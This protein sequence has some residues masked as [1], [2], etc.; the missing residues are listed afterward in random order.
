MTAGSAPAPLMPG[1][2][3]FHFEAPG[4]TACL[5]VHGF[6]G[7]AYELRELGLYLAERG[8]SARGVLLRGHGSRAEDMGRYSYRDWI[9]DVESA[10]DDLL[11][12][13]K[14]VFLAGLSMGGTLALNVAA[15]R[16]HEP[17][18]AGVIALSTPLRLADWRLSLLPFAGWL[19]RWH[20][21]GRPDIKD[22]SKWERHV[23]Y[24]RFHIRAVVQLM[25]LLRE[26]RQ[27]ATRVHQPLLVIQSR[28]DNTVPIFNAELILST[29][30]SEARRLLWLDNCYHVV[31]LD[32]DS[33][34]VRQ[35]VAAFIQEHSSACGPGTL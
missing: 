7:S 26:T 3:P 8:I 21:W 22:E 2:E 15:R 24:R 33:E 30:C 12:D 29:V 4:Q 34:R 35:E 31:T 5:L 13:G 9:A 32:Y 6:T 1:A 20:S 28:Q 17:R 18:L 10:L 25:R 11:A 27:L 14:R 19:W 23:A 16:S